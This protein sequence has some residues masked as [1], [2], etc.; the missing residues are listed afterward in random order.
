MGGFGAL[1]LAGLLG[2]DRVAAVAVAPRRCW[3]DPEDASDEG[4]EDAAEYEEF[5]IY[6][7]QDDLDGIAVRVDVG[8]GDPFYRD[9]QDYV[10]GFPDDADVVSTFEAGGHDAGYF[11]RMEPAQLAFLGEHLTA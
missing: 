11:R 7:S 9:V 2:P 10:A 6:D 3:K 1:R 4:F 8:T 5:S